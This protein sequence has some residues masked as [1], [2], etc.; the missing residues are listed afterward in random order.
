MSRRIPLPD[1][2]QEMHNEKKWSLHESLVKDLFNAHKENEI[3]SSKVAK[4]NLI[5]LKVNLASEIIK[6]CHLCERRCGADRT[7]G[8]LGYC[9]VPMESFYASEFI[10]IGEEPEIIP[11]HTIFFAGCTFRCMHCQN[12]DI[13]EN[14]TGDF[15]VDDDL[16]KR[17]EKRF[18]RGAKNVNLVGGNPD[19][20]LHNILDLFTKVDV[21][22]PVVWNSNMYHSSESENLLK[23]FVDLYLADFKYGPGDC[24]KEISDVDKYWE[25]VTRNFKSAREQADIYIRHLLLPGHVECCTRHIMEWVSNNLPKAKFNLM[26]QFHASYKSFGHENLGRILSSP[27]KQRATEMFS[28]FGFS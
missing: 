4:E 18:L 15:P 27:E 17:I 22:I 7:N 12:S 25:I 24:G 16:A 9:K 5:H 20:H 6:S 3:S 13:I 1:G 19:Q 26:F 11:S 14:P 2:W 21:P 10:H 28:E 23:G 8:E